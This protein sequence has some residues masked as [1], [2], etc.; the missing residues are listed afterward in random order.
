[1]IEKN[2]S[3]KFGLKIIDKAGNFFIENKETKMMRE[4]HNKGGMA[5]NYFELLV[6][7][8]SAVSGCV[9]ISAFATLV[10]I[11]LGIASLQ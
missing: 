11:P 3:Q 9:A 7:L 8:A 6:I 10:G 2:I 4:T 1:M 5:L